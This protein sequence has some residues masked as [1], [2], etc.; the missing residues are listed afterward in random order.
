ML[1]SKKDHTFR[2]PLS[3]TH[4]TSTW[5]A[6][7]NNRRENLIHIFSNERPLEFDIHPSFTN[8]AS[9]SK[10]DKDL[11]KYTINILLGCSI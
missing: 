6:C 4:F 2:L 9:E 10:F 1:L 8:T 3:C 7:E 11:R 5:N